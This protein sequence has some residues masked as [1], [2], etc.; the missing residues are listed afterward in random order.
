MLIG[1]GADT[2][3]QKATSGEVNW[4][5]VAVSGAFGAFGGVGVTGGLLAQAG[6]NAVE[7]AVENV[8]SYA[9]SSEP[10]TLQGMVT[11]AG[12][13]AFMSAATF[14]AM[15]KMPV[16]QSTLRLSDQPPTP[17]LYH[18]TDQKGLDGILESQSL[19]P[20]I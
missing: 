16:P 17:T 7:G 9:A 14:G 2:M 18:Y 19:H 5:Q 3:I 1:A 6:G 4:G 13:G 12:T 8:A 11:T 20:S 10:F 15:N